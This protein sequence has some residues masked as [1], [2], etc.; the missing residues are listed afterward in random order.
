MEFMGLAVDLDFDRDISFELVEEF[1]R[2]VVM[3]IFSGIWAGHDHHDVVV[4]LWRQIFVGH[5]WFEQVSILC[6]PLL[7]IERLWYRHGCLL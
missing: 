7:K 4:A 3:V 5:W 6:Q 2:F 1:F